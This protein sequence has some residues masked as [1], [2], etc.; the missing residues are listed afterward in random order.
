M[1]IMAQKL[2]YGACVFYLGRN[3]LIIIILVVT[4]PTTT[5]EQ[6]T[7][8]VLGPSVDCIARPCQR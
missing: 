6:E 4:S 1:M 2:G 7:G 3:D 5:A 8:P